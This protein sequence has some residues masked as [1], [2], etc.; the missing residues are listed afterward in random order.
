MTQEELNQFLND[1]T[2]S[3][4]ETNM[5]SFAELSFNSIDFG[6]SPHE[7]AI[8]ASLSSAAFSMRMT[9]EMILKLLNH[10]GV[11]SLDEIKYREIPPDFKVILGGLNVKKPEK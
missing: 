10:L 8:Q 7:I 2:A 6:A 11:I 5:S 9:S 3:A 1:I 4:L